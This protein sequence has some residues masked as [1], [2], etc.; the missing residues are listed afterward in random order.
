VKLCLLIDRRGHPVLEPTAEELARHGASVTVACVASEPI[1]DDADLYLLKSRSPR[2]LRAALHAE[3]HGALVLNSVAATVSCVDR[4]LLA[5]RMEQAGLPF[6]QTSRAPALELM[7]ATSSTRPPT[8]PIVVKS[9]RSRRG[10]LVRRVDSSAELRAL[11]AGWGHESVI[12]Q[13]LVGDDS[14]ELKLWVIGER[15]YGARRRPRFGERPARAD[16]RVPC[17]ELPPDIA[18]LARAAG[19]ALGL[20]LYGVDVLSSAA[21]PVIVDVNAF[22]GFRSVPAARELLADHIM[23]L[24]GQ[25]TAAA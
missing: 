7:I 3:L 9:R 4:V 1:P 25:E 21:G 11:T 13:P 17:E 14:W 23:S 12:A 5:K 22:P 20:E 19:A 6:P 8:W 16:V 18:Q 24:V 15:V 10:D 2:A